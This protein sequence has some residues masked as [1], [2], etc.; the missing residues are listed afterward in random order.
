MLLIIINYLKSAAVGTLVADEQ[1]SR[2]AASVKF[3]GTS[4]HMS[5]GSSVSLWW[6][7]LPSLPQGATG[8]YVV[9]QYNHST[10]FAASSKS[11]PNQPGSRPRPAR[12]RGAAWDGIHANLSATTR[13]WPFSVLGFWDKNT[14]ICAGTMPYRRDFS[15]TTRI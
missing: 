6:L 1:F 8:L 7:G 14:G 12:W 15:A 11:Q 9:G 13:N 2:T 10:P 5:C 3:S 4:T